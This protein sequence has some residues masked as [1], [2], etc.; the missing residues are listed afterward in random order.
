MCR[1]L[2]PTLHLLSSLSLQEQA[3][4]QVLQV[5]F[6][7]CWGTEGARSEAARPRAPPAHQQMMLACCLQLQACPAPGFSR[8]HHRGCLKDHERDHEKNTK[9]NTWPVFLLPHMWGSIATYGCISNTDQ[10]LGEHKLLPA[11]QQCQPGEPSAHRLIGIRGHQ[12]RGS[13]LGH[14]ILIITPTPFITRRE[15]CV[16]SPLIWGS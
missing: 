15:E 5:S 3:T 6:A 14:M 4:N 8:G 13:V 1:K 16:E 11:P 2:P 10:G 9:E 12:G 7:G